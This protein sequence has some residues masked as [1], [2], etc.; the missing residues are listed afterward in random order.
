[1]PAP[2]LTVMAIVALAGVWGC[3]GSSD[4][5][6]S[7]G[8][9][10][11]PSAPTPPP[12]AVTIT[13]VGERGSQSFNPNPASAAGQMVVF[14]NT[15]SVV[16]RVLLNDGSLDTGNI[17]PGATSAPL[18]MPAAGTNYHCPLH[19]AMIGAVNAASGPPPP[20]TGIYC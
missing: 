5:G 14:H 12:S 1:M 10:G 7:G 11:N 17:P 15:D 6:G 13:I 2:R 18:A 4:N 16:H 19:P 9:S 20:C 3:G 8:G